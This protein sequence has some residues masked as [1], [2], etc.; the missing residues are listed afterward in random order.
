MAAIGLCT[1]GIRACFRDAF[2]QRLAG[3][4]KGPLLIKQARHFV[5]PS[6]AKSVILALQKLAKPDGGP[7]CLN[8]KRR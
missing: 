1:P 5:A 2:Q 7:L 4:A 6:L 8:Q 3:C